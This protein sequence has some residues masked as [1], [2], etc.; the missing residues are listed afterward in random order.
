VDA[1]SIF[2]MNIENLTSEDDV[3]FCNV[4]FLYLILETLLDSSTSFHFAQDDKW[5]L[6]AFSRLWTFVLLKSQLIVSVMPNFVGR[7]ARLIQLSSLV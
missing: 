1:P 3:S 6:I 4:F 2:I 5:F 7:D